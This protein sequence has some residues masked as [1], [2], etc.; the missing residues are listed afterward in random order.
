ME[1]WMAAVNAIGLPENSPFRNSNRVPLL[2]DPASEAQAE[3]QEEDSSDK[4]EGTES[5]ESQELSRQIGSHVVVLDDDQ[6]RTKATTSNQTAQPTV[7]SGISPNIL[8]TDQEAPTIIPVAIITPE[9]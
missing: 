7:T 9:A 2:E 4:E 6:S 3:E 5:P 8:P 1:G